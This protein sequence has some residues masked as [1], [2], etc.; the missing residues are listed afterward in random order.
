MT[1]RDLLLLTEARNLATSGRAGAIRER[2]GLSLREIAD[3]CGASPTTVYRWERG[4]RQPRGRPAIRWALL[5]HELDQ[6]VTKEVTP[7]IPF[8]APTT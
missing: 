8:P 4:E 5:L 1:R 6:H 3:G 7:T 2:A